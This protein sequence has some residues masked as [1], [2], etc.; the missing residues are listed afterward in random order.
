M[1]QEDI[2]TSE[3]ILIVA[4]FPRKK[5]QNFEKDYATLG[6]VPSSLFWSGFGVPKHFLTSQGIWSSRENTSDMAV[7]LIP[8]QSMYGMLTYIYKKI[9]Q[10]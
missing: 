4:S 1:S 5:T 3:S 6:G 10:M 7:T 8:I 9:N 2:G